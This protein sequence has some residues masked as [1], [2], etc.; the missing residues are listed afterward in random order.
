LCVWAERYLFVSTT[1]DRVLC[2][3]LGTARASLDRIERV[4][5][6]Y[7]DGPPSRFKPGPLAMHTASGTLLCG[8]RAGNLIHMMAVPADQPPAHWCMAN[9]PHTGVMAKDMAVAGD[10]L[11]SVCFDSVTVQSI[12]PLSAAEQKASA[13]AAEQ[14][15]GPAPL[16]C[17]PPVRLRVL[18]V[19]GHWG[20]PLGCYYRPISIAVHVDVGRSGAVSVFIGDG[21]GRTWYNGRRIVRMRQT[22]KPATNE[23]K[24]HAPVLLPSSGDR[25]ADDKRAAALAPYRPPPPAQCRWNG[26][27]W[28][29]AEVTLQTFRTGVH[30]V[31][32]MAVVGDRLIVLAADVN[33]QDP[34][35]RIYPI[36]DGDGSTDPPITVLSAEDMPI[37]R[38]VANARRTVRRERR[39][40]RGDAAGPADWQT[41]TEHD[42]SEL[43]V[44]HMDKAKAR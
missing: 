27:G 41:A 37:L 40:P 33:R 42:L 4:F 10:L 6:P 11:F 25:A 19:L 17:A 39:R 31:N 43:Q 35:V 29:E 28:G 22:N 14:K 3:A 32:A 5:H 15:K 21:N 16:W 12:A 34:R 30:S 24:Q 13:L 20:D 44:L 23:R 1:G 18:S 38:A 9:A 26:S 36:R 7:H 8:D 2:Y